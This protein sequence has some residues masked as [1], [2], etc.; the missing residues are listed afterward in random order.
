M[1]LTET[2][3]ELEQSLLDSST[4]KNAQFVSSLL[5]DDFRE[6]GCSGR[7]YS[8]AE[9][10]AALQAESET[11][12]SMREF[13][14]RSLAGDAALVTYISTKLESGKAPNEALR[15]SIWALRGGQWRI[16]FH[17]GTMLPRAE[18]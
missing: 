1:K 11:R 15:S 14:A 6:F 5:A 13:E 9:I 7:I 8:K 2:L 3:R 18:T 12:I 16:V 17:Q 4:R 10:I